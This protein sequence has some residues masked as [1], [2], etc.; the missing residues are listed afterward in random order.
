MPDRTFSS[1]YGYEKATP[2]FQFVKDSVT[3]Q[4]RPLSSSD[5]G[6]SVSG[7]MNISGLTIH[8]DDLE[9]IASGQ[10]VVLQGVSGDS[11]A[12]RASLTFINNNVSTKSVYPFFIRSVNAGDT[13]ISQL[14]NSITFSNVGGVT[15][16]L[17]IN[18]VK[19]GL[20]PNEAVSYDGGGN[21]NILQT[22]FGYITSGTVF[23]MAG[24]SLD[25]SVQSL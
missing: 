22:S 17:S 1:A 7:G 11:A 19:K 14:L 25:P 4:W 6:V 8:V 15:G 5:M 10:L 24:T 23:V 3:N 2:S 18:G 16:F 21:G 9:R 13:T 12:M 20:G